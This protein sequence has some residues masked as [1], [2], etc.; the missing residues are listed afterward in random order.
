ML[1]IYTDRKLK[2]ILSWFILIS[3]IIRTYLAFSL[4]LGNDEV[5]YWTYAL[6]PDWSHFDH[7]PMV[8]LIIQLFTLNLTFDQV[9][10]LRLP[11]LVLGTVNTVIIYRIGKLLGNTRTGLLAAVLYT[12]SFYAFIVTG[13]FI[14]PD[15]PQLFFWLLALY[16][17]ACTLFKA[18]EGSQRGLPLLLAGLFTGLAMLSKYTS[19]YL[20]VGILLF[21]LFYRRSWF[22]N[23]YLYLS[24]GLSF[25][26]LLPVLWWNYSNDFVSFSYQGSRVVSEFR[27]RPDFFTTELAGELFYN[28]PVNFV[29]IIF[30]LYQ[31][32]RRR[33][34]KQKEEYGFILAFSLPLILTFWL[35]SWFR[36]TLPHWTGPAFTTIILAASLYFSE[37][38]RVLPHIIR[39]AVLLTLVTIVIGF[40]Q[41][42]YGLFDPVIAVKEDPRHRGA[43]DIS[44]DLYGWQELGHS[45]SA[46]YHKD[47]K[48]GRIDK[49]PVMLSWRWF[50]AANLDYYLARPLGLKLYAS[51]NLE[52]IHKYYWI[53]KIRGPISENKDAYFICSSRDE[54]DPWSIFSRSFNRFEGPDTVPV[55]RNGV[56]V[57]DFYFYRLRSYH[58]KDTK[59][60]SFSAGPPTE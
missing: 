27:L 32:F 57:M 40:S 42:K 45:F 36:G 60:R 39:S 20:W 50:P 23:P 19:I 56:R 33:L 18:E 5:Y 8:G 24:L 53:N 7:P 12:A 43:D 22:R 21:L 11:S 1:Q 51:G 17:F 3:L 49:D 30:S 37:R 28:N 14:L 13:V 6:F 59:L 10:F 52:K 41:I 26:F 38:Q 48:E 4:D 2:N 46:L 35:V 9:I 44:L 16:F 29:I 47:V 34:W 58:M 15:T 55:Y 54:L 31:V 25:L